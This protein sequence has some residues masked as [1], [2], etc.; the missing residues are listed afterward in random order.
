MLTYQD[1]LTMRLTPL[2]T[3]AGSWDRMADGFEDLGEVY[4]NTVQTVAT[5]GEWAGASADAAGTSFASTRKQFAAAATEARAIA[6]IL[7]DIHGQF[8]ERIAA[9]RKLVTSAKEAGLHVDAQGRARLDPSRAGNKEHGGLADA[10]VRAAQE[11]SWTAAVAAAVQAVDD[12]D[13]G[14]KLALR[15]AAGVKGFFEQA[16]DNAR[17]VGHGFNAGAIGDIE[18]VEAR[19]AKRYADRILAG[20][21]PADPEEWARLMR[22]NAGDEGFSRMVLSH[23]GPEGTIRLTNQINTLAYDSD[24]GNRQHYL[25]GERGLANALATATQNPGSPLYRQFRD[26]LKEAGMKRYEWQGE[27]VR[28]YQSLVTLMQHGEGYSDRFLH[29]LGD[30]LIAAERGDRGNDNW[31]LPARFTGPRDEWFANDPLDGLLGLMSKDPDAAAEFLDPESEGGDRLEYLT[32]Q[33]DWDVVDGN[34]YMDIAYNPDG[35]LGDPL[36]SSDMEDAKTRA[37]FGAALI[38]A[39]TGIDPNDSGGGY[40]QH[41]D[42][43]N[44]VFEGALKHLSAEGDDFPPSLRTPMAV[45][46]G[47]HGDDVHATTSAQL[48]SS[49]PLDRD[50][51]LEVSKQIS[52]DR[53]AYFTLQDTINHEIVHD[54]NTGVGGPEETWRKAGHTV[55]FLEEARYQGLAVDADDA[56]SK[57]MWEAKMDYHQWGG[58][59]N[60]IPQAGDAAQRGVDVLTTKWLEDETRHINERLATDNTETSRNQENRIGALADVWRRANPSEATGET[61]DVT[62]SK[63]NGTVN[64]GNSTARGLAGG[65]S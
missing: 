56:K 61:L 32:R 39:T 42:A 44:R 53:F 47:N 27:Q 37:G 20:E 31:D 15:D 17:G 24:S 5:G 41:S 16:L 18:L 46:M 62:V 58:L 63:I 4:G 7:R 25:S 43:N 13:E 38:A 19:E 49:S 22:D 21:K 45:V 33:R 26:G 10:T 3:A 51:V 2:T 35:I 64:D 57:A 40:V 14:A 9:V 23:L 30:D 8:T 65:G 59:V 36:R 54:I 1:V 29:D 28:G 60:F 55:G 52:R 6:S 48:D 34:R 12:A 50:Q 11:A